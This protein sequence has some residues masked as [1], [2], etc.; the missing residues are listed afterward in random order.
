MDKKQQRIFNALAQVVIYHYADVCYKEKAQKAARYLKRHKLINSIDNIDDAEEA[1]TQY[2]EMLTEYVKDKLPEE[3]KVQAD[4]WGAKCFSNKNHN[5]KDGWY[6]GSSSAYRFMFF[7]SF[8]ALE[9]YTNEKLEI[10]Q[11]EID[12][13]DEH[14]DY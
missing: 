3:Y 10:I 2:D 6:A 5:I 8:E 14:D 9:E 13:Q 11:Q 4:Y 12:M 7:N 1:Y